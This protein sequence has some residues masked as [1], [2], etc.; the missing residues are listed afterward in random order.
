M[1]TICSIHNFRWGRVETDI[2]FGRIAVREI[3]AKLRN[4]L[5]TTAR[6]VLHPLS[7]G[8]CVVTKMDRG[9]ANESDCRDCEKIAHDLKKIL[10][11]Y[12]SSRNAMI[13]LTTIVHLLSQFV[14]PLFKSRYC[15]LSLCLR[16]PSLPCLALALPFAESSSPA[17]PVLRA[18]QLS[19]PTRALFRVHRPLTGFARVG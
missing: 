2:R 19:S 8:N 9:T 4:Q 1:S 13:R 6:T 11:I 12:P 17:V 15:R 3:L 18:L 10:D 16:L 7:R 14:L 5:S